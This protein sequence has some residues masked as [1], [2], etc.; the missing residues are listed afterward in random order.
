MRW[1]YH[2][3]FRDHYNN[4]ANFL[5]NYN[6]I[7]NGRPIHGAVVIPDAAVTLVN[8]AFAESI[9]PTPILTATQAGMPQSLRYS[10]KFDF[11]PR[12][13]FAWRSD[14]K[15]VLRGGY[16]KYIE[17]E[18]GSLIN[19]AWAVEASDVAKFTNQIVGGKPLYSF[20]YALPADLAQ[21]GSQVFDL[22]GDIH[23][24]DPYVQQ[25]NF[26]V[27]RDLGF[28]TGLRV[29]YDG[30]HGTNLGVTTN[31]DQV[32]ANTVGFAAATKAAP[33]PLLAQIVY[34]TNARP[35]QL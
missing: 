28:Q 35:Q 27:E 1:E 30:S 2:P 12:V 7:Q 9:A 6:S 29:S 32:P 33:Y 34:L 31:P 4:T 25:W 3:A 26:T 20:P 19:A 17:A 24:K 15:T 16:G 23:Y 21:P 22:A 11:A 10:Q 8:P 14:G 13:G 5:P 18:L